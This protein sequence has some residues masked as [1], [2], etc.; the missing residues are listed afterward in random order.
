MSVW[1]RQNHGNS[2][3]NRLTISIIALLV[4]TL[5][6]PLF[7]QEQ[8]SVAVYPI[9]T[10]SGGDR[11]IAVGL[12]R[13]LI[14]KLIRTP[15]LRPIDG[16]R[17]AAKLNA[18]LDRK[19]RGPAWLPASAQRKVGQWLGA[20]LIM[21]G[22][23]G[24]SG[25]RADARRFLDGLSIVP[26]VT[27]DGSEVWV[28]AKLVDIHHGMAVSWA[29]AEGSRDGF[30]ELQDAL[31]LQI[32][33]DL[34]IDPG[35]MANGTIGR[36]TESMRAYQ[37]TLEAESILLAAR[38]A[39]KS[40][41]QWRRAAKK[42]EQ[43][44][45]L[46]PAYAKSYVIG[47]K[48]AESQGEL[49]QALA[50]YGQASALDPNYVAPRMAIAHLA[51]RAG[52]NASEISAL[53][54]VLEAA[55]WYDEAYDRIGVA[56]ERTG[57]TRLAA[58]YYD[59]ALRLFS[60]H[61]DRLYRG[62]SVHLTLGQFDRAISYLE[63]ATTRIPGERAYH[64]QLIRA[65]TRDGQYK[66]AQ[67]VTQT[68]LQIGA[69]S[70]DLW[71]AAGELALQQ[72]DYA[73][74]EKAFVR[75]LAE[76]PGRMEA[77]LMVAR[78]RSVRGDYQAAIAAYTTA[79]ADGLSIEDVVEPLAA[80]YIALGQRD[81]ADKVYRDALAKRPGEVDW[82][83][84]RSHILI[85]IL[86][87]GE[88]IPLLKRALETEPN[89]PDAI[90]WIA[91]SYAAIGNAAESIEK[92]RR[93][94]RIAPRR[95]H[96]YVR[97][98]DLSYRVREFEAARNAYGMAIAGGLGT[99]DVYAG[100]GL[101]EEE[102]AG[103]RNARTA[104]R[105]ALERDRS[106][107]IAK[108]GLQRMRLKIKPPR[109]EP[110]AADWAERGRRLIEAGDIEAAIDALER[111]IRKE[112]GNPTVLSNLGTAYARLNNVEGARSAFESAE[113]LNPTSESAYN[114]GRLSFQEGKASEAM[115]N[116]QIAIQRDG[117]FLTAA[118]NLA[119]LQAA[120]DDPLSAIKTLENTRSHHTQNGAIV[121]SLANT[122]YQAG[123][124]A[125]ASEL[126][127]EAKSL[128]GTLTDAEIG[129]GNIALT[130]GDATAAT[131]HY[132]KAIAADPED[133][134]PHVNLG[135]VLIQQELYGE[136]VA[137][138]QK[139]LELNPVD[140]ALHLNL[141]VLYYHTEQYAE[142]L[143]YCHAILEQDG[144]VI[145][146]Q[147]MIGDIAAT[148]GK[149]ELAVDAYRSVL[150]LH[151]EDLLSILG[152]AE[153]YNALERPDDAREHWQAWLDIVGDDPQYQAQAEAIARRLEGNSVSDWFYDQLKELRSYL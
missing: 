65:Y 75:V 45:R 21:T 106:N 15:E 126:Y 152:I 88:A 49:D 28:A 109:R 112:A 79:V 58:E 143:E 94:L 55:S 87:Y 67:E 151:S 76:Q 40:A 129:L 78:L 147:R 97:L 32:I 71:L 110:T 116:Y 70:T 83:L 29:F 136:A 89:H 153:A 25:N 137:S 30:F 84:A 36:P 53:Q 13:D 150:Q 12:S 98:G 20:D 50:G 115:L 133:P 100:M 44:L 128:S 33:S 46:D 108:A 131:A 95:T 140:L 11:W 4:A 113:R 125:R 27:P 5:A 144:S 56:Y 107:E 72:E 101:S 10:L 138:L 99:A 102:L 123:E 139:A 130:Q 117:S 54:S 77:R 48:A 114:L 103:Y 63:H 61:P 118:M 82:L 64:A 73:A 92:Y 35:G 43:S 16:D 9:G 17:V 134:D 80:A 69:E 66:R 7:A 2:E 91:S 34:G 26:S 119:S 8:A 23:V 22:L 149:H 127:N 121:V 96:A 62:G 86:R 142:A 24:T 145:Q 124:L 81:L 148:T 122:H 57:Q 132:R 141:S 41:R 6:S 19:A 146:A 3:M 104:Y 74:A 68:A 39:K 1:I 31:Y 93:L 38:S 18:I 14:E 59:R 51:N 52:D 85:E 42:I 105:K 135:T 90:E 47:A 111:S 37:L 120:A 60:D